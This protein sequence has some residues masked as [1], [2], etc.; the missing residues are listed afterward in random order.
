M[1]Y[2]AVF[3]FLAVLGIVL[4]F[5]VIA[6]A[7]LLPV[8]RNGACVIYADNSCDGLRE[9]R[10]LQFL[11]HIGFL[12]LPVFVVDLTSDG[13]YFALFPDGSGV[14]VLSMREWNDFLL[15]RE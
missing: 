2:T 3:V 11:R 12:L 15:R 14:T 13:R 1:V 9:I 5:T 4:L 6:S 8:C 7:L 10:G